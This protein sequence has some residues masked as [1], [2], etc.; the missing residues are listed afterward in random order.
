MPVEFITSK[1]YNHYYWNAPLIQYTWKKRDNLKKL[2]MTEGRG[3][4][5]S[6]SYD[7][8]WNQFEYLQKVYTLNPN[9]IEKKEIF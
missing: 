9:L 5:K 1:I 3:W 6:N 2:A 7:E 4:D 8:G